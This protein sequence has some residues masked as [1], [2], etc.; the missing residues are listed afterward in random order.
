MKSSHIALACF[1]FSEFVMPVAIVIPDGVPLTTFSIRSFSSFWS[2]ATLLASGS[3]EINRCKFNALVNSSSFPNLLIRPTVSFAIS[4]VMSNNLSSNEPYFSTKESHSLIVSFVVFLK[5]SLTKLWS[6]D[7]FFIKSLSMARLNFLANSDKSLV[8]M[9]NGTPNFSTNSLL[10]PI[11]I[12]PSPFIRS[13][14]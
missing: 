1:S 5:L 12:M 11:L 3:M 9:S 4:L 13:I 6:S 2:S 8:K 7:N 14:A 10:S